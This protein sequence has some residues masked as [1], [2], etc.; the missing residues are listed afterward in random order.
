MLVINT[1]FPKLSVK[2]A[3]QHSKDKTKPLLEGS[4]NLGSLPSLQ[5]TCHLN[6]NLIL[7]AAR[8]KQNHAKC[9]VDESRRLCEA[10]LSS[11]S[12]FSRPKPNITTGL[13]VRELQFRALGHMPNLMLTHRLI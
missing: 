8:V 9:F 2:K 10:L 13:G 11:V 12:L 1:N 6:P 3:K 4:P 5:L 7:C